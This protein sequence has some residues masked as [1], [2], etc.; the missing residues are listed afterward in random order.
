MSEVKE[1]TLLWSPDQK[2]IENAAVTKYKNWIEENYKQSFSNQAE[3]WQWSVDELSDFWE[4]VWTYFDVQSET[5][6]KQVLKE[7]TMPGATWFEGSTLNYAEH[8][9]R[10]KNN[11]KPAILFRSENVEKREVSWV[12][13]EDKT[14]RLA[15]HL[16]RLGV[17]QGDR[18]VAYMPNVPE[19]VVGLLATASIGAIWSVCSPDF[20]TDSVLERFTQIRPKVL[21]ACDGYQYNGK[22][23]NRMD[24]LAQIQAALPTLEETIIFENL[25]VAIEGLDEE[26]TLRWD[27][28]IEAEAA[29]KYEQVPFDQPL[30]VLFSSGTTGKPKPIVQGQGGIL[31]EQL[32]ILGIEHGVTVEDTYFWYSATG[33]MMWNFLV[34]NLQLGATVVLYD[35]SPGYPNLDAMWQLLEDF[36][37]TFFGTSAAFITS[38][39]NAEVAP[40]KISDFKHLR[41]LGSTGSPL[42]IN[43]FAW[44]YRAI[45]ADLW[46]V[47]TSGG[48]DLCTAFVGGVPTLPVHAGEIQTRSL[49]ASVYSYNEAGEAVTDEVGELVI[50]KPMPSMPLYFW[51]DQ[52]N[53]R[54]L[55][56][57]FEEY[58]GVWRHGDWIKIDGKG[59]CVIYGRS[60]STINRQGVRLGT[61]E[62]YRVIDAQKEI[63]DSLVIDLELL[64]RESYMP[65]FVV[66]NDGEKLTEELVRRLKG[67]VRTEVSPRF[68]PNDIFE[69]KAIPRTLSGKKM[70][71]PIRKIL[72][73]FD[74][75][76]VVNTGA[77]QN[78]ESLEYFVDFA[79]KLNTKA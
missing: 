51:G 12:E 10:N 1:G 11:H 16:R 69:I 24:K 15:G 70:E 63:K 41:G 2:Q 66:L 50:T 28:A 37:V 62:I 68:A 32:K 19:T 46:V 27:Q 45:K 52:D 31:L 57:Y 7:E 36:K 23:Y 79:K 61:S 26:K 4:S 43:A 34:G 35:G 9:F 30:W 47:S 5:P 55:G 22:I 54:Y 13:L 17:K 48:T 58:E 33:W 64:G 76:K 14:A 65:L 18:V 75:D 6:Y 78:P 74:K 8:V 39:M 60:D 25:G 40:Q 42:T 73:G 67:V 38:C 59:S 49:G 29:P 53:S 56:S 44:I 20:G 77:M 71:I 72:L 21:I 3:L